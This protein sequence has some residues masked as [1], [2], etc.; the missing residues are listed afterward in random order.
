MDYSLHFYIK[1]ECQAYGKHE[2]QA[3]V[4]IRRAAFLSL[5]QTLLGQLLQVHLHGTHYTTNHHHIHK[6]RKHALFH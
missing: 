2:A 1:K 5:F 6:R 4:K 3:P